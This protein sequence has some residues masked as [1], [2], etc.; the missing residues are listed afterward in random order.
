MHIRAFFRKTF[1]KA[2]HLIFPKLKSFLFKLNPPIYLKLKKIYKRIK[3]NAKSKIAS[4][5]KVSINQFHALS[6]KLHS[7]IDPDIQIYSNRYYCCD[8]LNKLN[9]HFESYNDNDGKAV[10]FCCGV[11]DKLPGSQYYATAEE[12]VNELLKN[13]NNI[14]AESK[15]FSLLGKTSVNE[16]RKFTSTCV[17]CD[18]FQLKDWSGSDG[19]IHHICLNMNPMPCQ[20]RCIYCDNNIFTK[21]TIKDMHLHP[22]NYKR[23]FDVIDHLKNNGM[24]ADSTTWNIASGEITIH[25]FK[26]RIYNLVGK[27]AAI[28]SSNCFIYDKDIA[29]NLASNPNSCIHLSID[30]GTPK[31][32]KKIKGAN[33][34]NTVLDNLRKY[35]E[36][37][38]VPGQILLKYI[39]LP[40]INDNSEDYIAVVEIMK[41]LK[42]NYITVSCDI[43]GKNLRNEKQSKALIKATGQ[44]LAELK[45]NSMTYSFSPSFFSSY[46]LENAIIF[47]DT[48]S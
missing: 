29:V 16:I 31:T 35:S 32:W 6:E 17:K 25:P 20:S 23:P 27:Q 5:Q 12:T 19:L 10:R 22:E 11:L 46:E 7:N 39:I 47:A 26:E 3:Q 37:C 43:R 33:N 41:S 2:N 34:F 21:E 13:Y 4:S 18:L 36:S 8:Y 44:L 48:I 30:S 28:Y 42:V 40:G 14:V 15:M 38:I 24:I 45:K 1:L 9:L